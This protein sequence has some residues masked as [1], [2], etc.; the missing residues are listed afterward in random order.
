[1]EKGPILA[2]KFRKI[3]ACCPRCYRGENPV[4]AP[5]Q[6]GISGDRCHGSESDAD[7]GS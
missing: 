4:D 5:L 1:M 6:T 7:S 2:D 3:E